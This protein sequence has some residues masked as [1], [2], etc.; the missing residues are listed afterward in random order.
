MEFKNKKSFLIRVGLGVSIL[1]FLVIFLFIFFVSQKERQKD[2][3]RT[4]DSDLIVERT[5]VFGDRVVPPTDSPNIFDTVSVEDR[6]QVESIFSEKDDPVASSNRSRL[7]QLFS[8]PVS[9]FS[10]KTELDKEK[11]ALY[12]VQLVTRGIG[13]IYTIETSPYNI[14]KENSFSSTKIQDGLSLPNGSFVVSIEDDTNKLKSNGVLASQK[15][16]GLLSFTTL[17]ENT[18]FVQKTDENKFFVL[19]KTNEGVVGFVVDRD[20]TTEKAFVWKN[21]FSSWR[22]FW[23]SNRNIFLQTAAS[24]LENGYFYRLNETG[25]LTKFFGPEQGLLVLHN[26]S[27]NTSLV[28]NKLGLFLDKEQSKRLSIKIDTLPEKCI[29]AKKEIY[30]SVPRS[31][32]VPTRSGNE[33]LVPDSWYRGD[34]IYD[35]SFYKINTETTVVKKIDLNL[36]GE[37]RSKIDLI[38]PLLSKDEKFLFFQNKIDYSLWVLEL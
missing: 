15:E 10:V 2:Q 4:S 18:S 6:S 26:E 17:G 27:T 33:T 23:G 12:L 9:G 7:F 28:R 16:N 20:S 24:E 37:E 35:D 13:D 19:R 36:D 29:F 5:S 22:A 25:V 31:L 21:S 38:N 3:T 8:G 32:T 1:C 30:C 34:V 14:V 11:D